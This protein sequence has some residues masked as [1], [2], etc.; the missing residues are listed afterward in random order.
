MGVYERKLLRKIFGS[1]KVGYHYRIRT[2]RELYELFNDIDVANRI[3]IQRIR[4]LGWMDEDAPQK[5]VFDAVVGGHRRV[6]GPRTRWKD[7]VEEALTSIGMTSWR[8]RAQ[9]RGP[10]REA[11]RQGESRQS[12]CCGHISKQ[13]G[14]FDS[15]LI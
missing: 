7:Q 5:R 8:R 10:W 11:L 9:S 13:V 1:V 14:T 15:H 6:G 12:D 4:W 3:N 2:N